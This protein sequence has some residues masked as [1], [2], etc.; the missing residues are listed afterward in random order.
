MIVFPEI[1]NNCLVGF[2]WDTEGHIVTNYHVLGPTVNDV[3]ITFLNDDGSRNSWK[4]KVRG[5]DKDKDIAVLKLY[6]ESDNKKVLT[7]ESV[8][9]I[10][11][12][13]SKNL[14]VGQFA[15]AIGNPFGLDQTITTGIVSG[16]GRQVASPTRRPI[17][18]MIQTDAAINPGNSGGPLLDSSGSVIGMNT[19]I[20]STS[21]A[22][23]GNNSPLTLAIPLMQL[24]IFVT[25]ADDKK[26]MRLLMYR[27]RHRI[28]YSNRHC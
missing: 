8:Q 14:R 16:L 15:I 5:V 3:L 7:K 12:G 20:L 6:E 18:N 25:M 4:A 24:N 10:Q 28:C 11:I 17:Y 19:A 21:G 27:Y 23:A 26:V 22:S 13:S 2:V 9:A 1:I